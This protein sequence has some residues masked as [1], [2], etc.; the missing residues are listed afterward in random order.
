MVTGFAI[1]PSRPQTAARCAKH[2]KLVF[3]A[4]YYFTPQTRKYL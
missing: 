3:V 2:L 4:R 1:Q